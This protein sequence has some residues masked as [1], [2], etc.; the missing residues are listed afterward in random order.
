MNLG[1]VLRSLVAAPSV[2]RCSI[3]PDD[4]D[5]HVEW[6]FPKARRQGKGVAENYA[7]LSYP[8]LACFHRI[9]FMLGLPTAAPVVASFPG[10]MVIPVYRRAVFDALYLL[11][12]TVLPPDLPNWLPFIYFFL[13]CFN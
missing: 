11:H 12:T 2:Y 1:Q 8:G 3:Y 7:S 10:T 13:C 6:K 5:T 9:P 4:S